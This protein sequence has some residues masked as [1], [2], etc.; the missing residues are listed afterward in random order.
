[1]KEINNNE[2]IKLEIIPSEERVSSASKRHSVASKAS[3]ESGE[4]FDKM[5]KDVL[6]SNKLVC[7]N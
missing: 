5:Y 2:N 7:P 1:M 4:M 6:V 3:V